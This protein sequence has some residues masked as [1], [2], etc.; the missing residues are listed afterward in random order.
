MLVQEPADYQ[1]SEEAIELTERNSLSRFHHHLVQASIRS[2][3]SFN[4]QCPQQ[5]RLI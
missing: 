5:I 4:H 2:L 1:L 3:F